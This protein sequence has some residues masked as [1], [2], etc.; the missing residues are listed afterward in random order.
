ME[1]QPV[2]PSTECKL[3]ID[4]FQRDG[5]KLNDFCD[6]CFECGVKCRVRW[7]PSGMAGN[8]NNNEF[9]LFI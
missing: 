4:I 3:T 5:R 7:H 6:N 1:S 8:Q 2:K 9:N